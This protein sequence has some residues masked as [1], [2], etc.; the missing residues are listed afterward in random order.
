M[1]LESTSAKMS[2]LGRREIM[3]GKIKTAEEMLSALEDVSLNDVNALAKT[4]LNLDTVSLAVVGR[5]R[6]GNFIKTPSGFNYHI[7][8][9]WV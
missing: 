2:N 7:K 6:K 1:G 5:C 8:G 9:L 3:T 4:D